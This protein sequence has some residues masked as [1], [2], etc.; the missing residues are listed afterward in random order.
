[1]AFDIGSQNSF[2]ICFHEP[3]LRSEEAVRTFRIPSASF[4]V[5]GAP[6]VLTTEN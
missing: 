5:P 1:L 3:T 2:V 6:V 4:G